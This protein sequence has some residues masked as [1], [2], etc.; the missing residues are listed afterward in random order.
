[1]PKKKKPVAV[2]RLL[3]EKPTKGWGEVDE[4]KVQ[5]YG[6][7]NW[8]PD[9]A[10][11]KASS[12]STQH[13]P[14]A[15]PGLGPLVKKVAPSRPKTQKEPITLMFT[16]PVRL[17]YVALAE[18]GAQWPKRKVDIISDGKINV[19]LKTA[20]EISQ[21]REL[22]STLGFRILVLD[23]PEYFRRFQEMDS[24]LGSLK[25]HGDLIQWAMPVKAWALASNK[26]D[27]YN[28]EISPNIWMPPPRFQVR[29]E[30]EEGKIITNYDRVVKSFTDGVKNVYT[31]WDYDPNSADM[32]IVLEIKDQ[33]HLKVFIEVESTRVENPFVHP[34][35]TLNHKAV[36]FSLLQRTKLVEGEFVLNLNCSKISVAEELLRTCFADIQVVCFDEQLSAVET[37]IKNAAQYCDLK[38]SEGAVG[39][40]TRLP[41]RDGTFDVVVASFYQSAS[42]QINTYNTFKTQLMEIARMLQRSKGIV[43]LIT[44]SEEALDVSLLRKKV[45]WS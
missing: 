34:Y 42:H 39:R 19:K 35:P 36:T 15:P 5:D 1:M 40:M 8:D 11:Q 9:P 45:Y 37:S 31:K 44:D 27:I 3:F 29:C 32:N 2:C 4:S 30:T 6:E 12:R 22:R 16:V 24:L 13:K 21:A 26:G 38:T 43:C 33:I 14:G 10:F 18:I 7:F 17:E 20:N 25:Y 41:F 28:P 23:E